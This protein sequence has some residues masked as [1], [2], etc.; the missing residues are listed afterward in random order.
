MSCV[1]LGGREPDL[2]ACAIGG[3]LVAMLSIELSPQAVAQ[4]GFFLLALQ[5]AS[6]AIKSAAR[7]TGHLPFADDDASEEASA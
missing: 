5:G 3:L 4:L 6:E 7:L 2:T 1:I